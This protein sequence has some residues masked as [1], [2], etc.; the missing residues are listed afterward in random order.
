MPIG[1]DSRLRNPFVPGELF[2][3]LKPGSRRSRAGRAGGGSRYGP[4]VTPAAGPEPDAAAGPG[5]NAAP[6]ARPGVPRRR[7]LVSAAALVG[8][9][10]ASAA[11]PSVAGAASTAPAPGGSGSAGPARGGVVNVTDHGAVGNG[12]T[13]DTAAIQAAVDEAAARGGIAFFPPGHYRLAQPGIRV[14]RPV[15][16]Q[17]VGWE[18][19][20]VDP[21]TGES[22]SV[23]AG[24]WL[25]C[26][27][28]ASSAIS[29]AAA[30][31]GSPPSGVIIRDLAVRQPQ[32]AGSGVFPEP[33]A[34]AGFVPVGSPF[35]IAIGPGC[36]DVLLERLFL[37]N[38]TRGISAGLTT[39]PPTGRLTLRGIWGQPLTDGIVLDNCQDTVRIEDVHFWPYWK[40]GPVADWQ[41]EHGTGITLR[42]VDNPLLRGLLCFGYAT[43]LRLDTGAPGSPHKVKVADADFDKCRAGI[44]VTVPA[45]AAGPHLFTNVSIQ[46]PDQPRSDDASAVD[47]VG[48]G[49]RVAFTNL[50]VTHH[51]GSAVRV[52]GPGCLV[53]ADMLCV[54]DVDLA[55]RGVAVISA[56]GGAAARIGAQRDIKIVGKGPET[57]GDVRM[58]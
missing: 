50:A 20:G 4:L 16:L 58:G 18:G 49:V 2:A 11:F 41:L 9:A 47:I 54:D 22:A 7:L 6:P 37:L 30:P 5:P 36:T 46:G 15:Q 31:G 19:T 35:A 25:F 21:G 32:P 1:F 23:P 55:G 3:Q 56:V 33:V 45:D 40:L 14:T 52:A 8:G 10:S 42:R 39:G 13:D 44:R 38:V 51:G 48:T 28:P 53:L 24:S 27:D 17:G 26:D 57:E 34:K 12:I 43:G 29:V